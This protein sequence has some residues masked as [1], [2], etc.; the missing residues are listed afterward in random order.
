MY[1]STNVLVH[2][3]YGSGEVE[4]TAVLMYSYTIGIVVEKLNILQY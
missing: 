1:C 3:R 2:Y 4:C